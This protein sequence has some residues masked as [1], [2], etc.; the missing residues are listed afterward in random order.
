MRSRKLILPISRKRWKI[1]LPNL[2][3]RRDGTNL[4]TSSHVMHR[5]DVVFVLRRVSFDT[6]FYQY[7]SNWSRIIPKKLNCN[8]QN[9]ILCIEWYKTLLHF[10]GMKS[11]IALIG[12]G[13]RD[14]VCV[15]SKFASFG[16]FKSTCWSLV[17]LE[18]H[19]LSPIRASSLPKMHSPF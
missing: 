16:N 18:L 10:A 7:R 17:T 9:A 6:I 15:R 8:V 5:F 14:C 4:L 19:P 13:S 11:H 2:P 3:C 12:I 1:G